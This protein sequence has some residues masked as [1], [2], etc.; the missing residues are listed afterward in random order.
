MRLA[1]PGPFLPL[2]LVL[3]LLLPSGAPLQDQT[4][5]EAWIREGDQRIRAGQ[6][7]E[8]RQI[9]ERAQVAA[10]ALKAELLETQ[11][12][13]AL[14]DAQFHLAKYAEAERTLEQCL[15]TSEQLQYT[16]GVAR[17][18][19]SLSATFE[20]T[21]KAVESVDHAR[22]AIVAFEQTS[23]RRGRA[24]ATLQ[25][26]RVTSTP[27][28]ER[29]PLYERTIEDARAAGDLSL[30]GSA[31]HAWGDRLFSNARYEEAFEKLQDA[32]RAYEAVSA[33]VALGTVHNSLGRLYRVHGRFD[34]ALKSQLKALELHQSGNNPFLLLQSL[35]AVGAV[36]G[37]MGDPRALEY[38]EKALVLAERTSSPRIQDF[39]RA[40]LASLLLQKG[41]YARAATTLEGVIERKLDAYLSIRYTSLAA[42]R[43]GLGKPEAALEAAEK[44]V[45]VCR[46]GTN[47]CITAR[48]RRGETLMALG[49]DDEAIQEFRTALASIE[50][51]RAKLLPADFLRQNF[52]AARENVYS[53]AIFL[54]VRQRHEREALETAEQARARAFLDLLASRDVTAPATPFVSA[55]VAAAARR[56]NSTFL[57]YWVSDDAVYAWTV[58][59]DGSM[60]VRR[61]PVLR[62]RLT[63]LVRATRPAG[64]RWKQDTGAWRQLH[65]LLIAPIRAS[66]PKRAGALV[67]IVPHGPLLNLSFAALRDARGRYL[68]EDYTLHYVPAAAVLDFTGRR[69]L[70]T[71]MARSALIVADPQ[72]PARSQLAL[73]LQRL[74]GARD[75]GRSI[76]S[77]LPRARRVVLEDAGATESGIRM[78][79]TQKSIVHFATHAVLR[80]DDPFASF[81]ALAAPK[82]KT[83]D[84][85]LTAAEIY[86]WKLDADLVMLSACQSG[87]G[88]VTGDGIATFARAFLYAGTSSLVVSLWDVADEPSNRL[89]PSFYRTWLGGATKASALRSAQLRLLRDLRANVVEVRTAAGPVSIPE[90]PVFWAGFALIGEPK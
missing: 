78:A 7:D 86:R 26:L 11:A 85:R 30:E 75:E 21:G 32:S 45:T 58:A 36:Y 28:A 14:G 17:G 63:E 76:A 33:S 44:A 18:H 41:D 54:Q 49:R 80:D 73:P 50:E 52:H 74:P 53:S 5:V 2:G 84:G 59:A 31:L 40:N 72:L 71:D 83:D 67:T 15:R 29:R 1:L 42:A 9:L 20:L 3:F 38:Q 34:E 61:T 90:H 4:Q 81:L 23:D 70:S 10:S 35:N 57:L 37:Y 25:L 16:Y 77:L 6:F 65:E 51:M 43:L 48:S 22:A 27:E 12:R 64:Q 66:L 13:C 24:L 39:V 88:M 62:A 8:A 19:L 69:A 89:V 56:L 68:L 46:S 60:T 47:E 87:N 55:D 79:A 82:D